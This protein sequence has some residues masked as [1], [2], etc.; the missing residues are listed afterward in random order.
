MRV[1]TEKQWFNQWW[2]QLINLAL[3]GMLLYFWYKWWV[4]G[5][6]VDKVAPDDITG[7]VVV[8]LLL[9][10]SFGVIYIFQLHT[11]IDDRGIHYRFFPFHRSFK[12]IPWREMEKCYTRTYKPLTEYGGWGYKFGTVGGKA[13]NVKGNQGVQIQFKNGKK[14]LIGTQKPD[15]AQRIIKRYFLKDNNEGV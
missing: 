11:K 3:L 10:L 4:L 12:T 2:M 13:Y 8:S 6:K 15:D 7:Q 5:D 1:F 14:L 9:M